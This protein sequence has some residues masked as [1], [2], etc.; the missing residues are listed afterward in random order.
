MKTDIKGDVSEIKNVMESIR[1]FMKAEAEC[2][3]N[4][5]DEVTSESMGNTYTMETSLLQMLESQETT[6]DDYIAYLEKMNEEFQNHLSMTNQNLLFSKTLKIKPIPETTQPVPPVFKRGQFSKINVIRLLGI[7]YVPE[8]SQKRKIINRIDGIF[9]ETQFTEKQTEQSREKSD[10]KPPLS[11]SSDVT[12]IRSSSIPG[13]NTAAHVSVGK[14]GRL[15]VSDGWGDLVEADLKGNHLQ[16]IVTS[17]G[18]E[19]YHAVT[20]DGNLIYRNKNKKVICKIT[21]DRII[22]EFIKTGDWTPISVHSSRINGDILVSMSKDKDTKLTRYSKTGK[23]IQNIQRDQKGHELYCNPCYITENING[24]ICASETGKG[25]VVVVNGS[26]QHR[27]SYTGQDS[28]LYPYG[29]VTDVLGHILVCDRRSNTVHILDKDGRFLTA[30]HLRSHP[31][32]VCV[33]DENNLYVGETY[34]CAVTV[35]RYLK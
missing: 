15:W 13:V 3:K 8:R 35:Y 4:L 17:G 26:G 28:G 21:P 19:S 30:L 16:E 23:E 29:I 24:D 11:L 20:Q 31:R 6:Y 27:F 2:L 1:K 18:D 9:E 14:S 7:V 32:G 33:D 10:F 25:S 22:T 12:K 5:V 34:P